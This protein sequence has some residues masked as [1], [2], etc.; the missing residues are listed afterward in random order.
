MRKEFLLVALLLII[1][2]GWFFLKPKEETPV[3]KCPSTCE[4]GCMPGTTKCREPPPLAC[5]ST[6]LWGCFPNTTEC[7]PEPL[8]K[9]NVTKCG[10]V[11]DNLLIKS[12]T[13]SEGTCMVIQNDNLVVD[14]NGFRM[15]GSGKTSSYGFYIVGRKNIT[16]LNCVLEE[17]G[18]GVFIDSS[19]N[20]TISRVTTSKNLES[21]VVVRNSNDVV[22]NQIIT[23]NNGG[24]GVEMSNSNN[25]I[26]SNSRVSASNTSVSMKHCILKDFSNNLLCSEV[27]GEVDLVCDDVVFLAGKNNECSINEGCDISCLLCAFS[28]LPES[29]GNETIHSGEA[30][31]D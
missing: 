15:K 9:E 12:N 11:I 23:T 24:V 5:P 29:I 4:Y 18:I 17:F 10:A 27:S 14:C 20:V 30:E 19:S 2:A 25:I 8:T 3:V 28:D 21:G 26:F 13:Q 7:K 1:A 16:I 6:C 22:L 31:S